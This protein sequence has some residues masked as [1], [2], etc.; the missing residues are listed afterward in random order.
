M[1]SYII[2]ALVWLV[3]FLPFWVLYLIA[4]G[5]YYILYYIVRYRRKIV[6]EN[7]EHSFPE[8]TSRERKEIEKKFYRHLSDFFVEFF[9]PWHMSQ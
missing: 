2:Y 5:M 8:K 6:A 3:S 7:L 4:D 9:K 1:F